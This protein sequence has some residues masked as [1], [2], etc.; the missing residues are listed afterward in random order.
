M[1]RELG[2]DELIYLLFAARWTIA[3]TAAA[4]AGGTLLGLLVMTLRVTPLAPA[5]WLAIAF[6]QV[7]QGT[8]LLGQLFIFYFGL[9]LFGLDV[10]AWAAAVVAFSLYS[11]AFM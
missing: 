5:R 4:L 2:T 7:I 3:L 8:P 11:S 6:I 10:S 9:G 1:I